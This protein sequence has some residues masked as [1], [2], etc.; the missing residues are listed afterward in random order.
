[1]KPIREH[2]A[3]FNLAG[4]SYYEGA[5]CF[6]QLEIGAQVDVVLEEDNKYDPRAI[7]V[8]FKDYKL[9]FVPRQE[10]RILY[11]LLKVGLKTHIEMRIQKIDP[12][13][14]PESQIHIVAHLIATI[15][16]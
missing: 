8:Y 9:G 4:F 12:T 1:M 2:L 15:Q 6:K 14:H 3:N 10:N 7:A 11:K 16:K 13:D 5:T